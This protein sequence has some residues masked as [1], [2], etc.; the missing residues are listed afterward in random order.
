MLSIFNKRN[1]LIKFIKWSII[2][3][4]I[5]II[6]F[7]PIY[8]LLIKKSKKSNSNSSNSSG[9]INGN[10]KEY[11][12]DG[13]NMQIFEN[14]TNIIFDLQNNKVKIP[15]SNID[16]NNRNYMIEQ[17]EYINSNPIIE[18]KKKV[19]VISWLKTPSNSAPHGE[20]R[21]IDEF[22][23]ESD[24]LIIK[25]RDFSNINSK[26][27]IFPLHTHILHT[28]N[29]DTDYNEKCFEFMS[30]WMTNEYK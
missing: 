20:K 19:C 22:Y 10:T 17:L 21:Y 14:N 3:I 1:T 30:F 26:D 7:L 28:C 11:K 15:L 6:L 29:N 4:I 8:F 24:N 25:F 2:L 13:S 5:G 16:T 18:N 9:I 27:D 12:C 23:I